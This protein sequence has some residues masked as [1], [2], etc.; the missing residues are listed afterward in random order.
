[1]IYNLLVNFAYTAFAV[2][3][4]GL[5]GFQGVIAQCTP[6]A[7]EKS[8]QRVYRQHKFFIEGFVDL[9]GDGKPD[10][11]GYQLQPNGSY[12]NIIVLPNNGSGGFGNPI[13]SPTTFPIS[14]DSGKNFG[15]FYGSMIVGDLNNDGKRD[16][17]LRAATS[18]AAIFTMIN[19]GSGVFTQTA[20]SLY[21]GERFHSIA[22]LNGDGRGDLVA[23]NF[24]QFYETTPMAVSGS[25]GY[26]MANADGTFGARVMIDSQIR[27]SP[28]VADF[29]NDG[30]P[31]IAYSYY[32][33][34]NSLYYVKFLR[35]LGGGIFSGPA[36]TVQ[37]VDISTAADIDGDGKP[38]LIATSAILRNEGTGEFTKQVFPNAPA[39]G[40]Q[41]SYLYPEN[42][43][44][45]IDY[46]GDGDKDILAEYGGRVVS[47]GDIRQR[48]YSVFL[49]NGTGGL[50]RL[51]F[52]KRLNGTAVDV[53]GD[54]KTD[55][56]NVVNS[57]VGNQRFSAT[58]EP[59]V[60]VSLPTC[61]SL[62]IQGQTKLVDIRGDGASDLVKWNSGNGNWSYLSNVYSG[63]I[64][65]GLGSLGDIPAPGDFDGDGKTDA[66]V[67]RNSN[68]SWWIRRSSD[69]TAISVYF[70]L[71]GDI[72]VPADYNGDGK[73]DIAVFRPSDGVWYILISGTG[74][75]IIRPFGANG[76][77]PV[78][79]DYDGD[80]KFDIAIF[81]PATGDWWIS[82]SSDGGTSVVNWGISTDVPIPADYDMDGKAD[83]SV[84][85]QGIW[86]ILRS[87]DNNV[88]VSQFGI[89][90]DTPMA[91]D[92]NGD[93]VLE[94][95]V[96]RG[97]G[98]WHASPFPNLLWADYSASRPLRIF[99]PNN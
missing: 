22:D 7:Y 23:V 2:V 38:D 20:V 77:K 84:F 60:Q 80:G 40:F 35:N 37:G 85:R 92:S 36:A 57:A 41:T 16:A 21:D 18:P 42:D 89:S 24:S 69:G 26:R 74:E 4:V 79:Q 28:A 8:F 44:S 95:S 39:P 86:Y 47:P 54:G 9:T 61:T 14:N 83:I 97:A 31:D 10:A 64:N 50:T 76:D 94:L 29:D 98:T 63:T 19:N 45:V 56:V 91:V 3:L 67:Y 46:D 62:P 70:G 88:D 58:N 32:S 66:A 27:L 13:I 82:K 11:Y 55:I 49:N 71:P 99:Q 96:F 73:S 68:G 81:R 65:W 48:Y 5:A 51:N 59:N 43:I 17:V 87:Y 30:K 75:V 12:Q 6:V 15:Y 53:N 25:V 72:P 90:G 78:V 1:M 52:D 93:G 34:S 33:G